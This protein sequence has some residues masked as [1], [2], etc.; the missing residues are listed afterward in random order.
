MVEAD[1]PAPS[2]SLV[3]E[4]DG[5]R[6][7]LRWQDEGARQEVDVSVT[8]GFSQIV[9]LADGTVEPDSSLA[10]TTM[11]LPLQANVT[12]GGD[13]RAVTVVLDTPSGSN[14]N[15][16]DDIATAEG[17]RVE[18]E[19]GD[20]GVATGVSF[21]A[22]EDAS[23]TALVSVET[24]FLQWLTTPVV[25]PSDAV[26]TGAR[27]TVENPADGDNGINQT[28]TYTLVSRDGDMV[29]LD[30]TVERSADDAELID[31]ES[32]V[33]LSV[34]DNGTTTSSGSLTVD[35]SKPIPVDGSI[36][37]INSIIYGDPDP[38]AGSSRITQRAL[39]TIE[40]GG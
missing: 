1:L 20:D 31:E 9:T 36:S 3:D 30:A 16:R 4:G 37:F 12:G 34:I 7:V 22:P 6:S 2:V 8:R 19:S 33:T 24:A 27:W 38:E 40:F 26:G 21:G 28:I 17:F 5:E 15:L 11:T 18:M 25:F 39:R 32:G 29:E 23:D 13:N 14:E 35:L 10:D